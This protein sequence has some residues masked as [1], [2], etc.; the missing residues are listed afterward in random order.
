MVQNWM[1]NRQNAN[2][3]PVNACVHCKWTRLAFEKNGTSMTSLFNVIQKVHWQKHITYT[4]NALRSSFFHIF[5]LALLLPLVR[6]LKLLSWTVFFCLFWCIIS[7]TFFWHA[8]NLHLF[9]NYVMNSF[10]VVL[11]SIK[12]MISRIQLNHKIREEQKRKRTFLPLEFTFCV[13]CDSLVLEHNQFIKI[14]L[15]HFSLVMY[16]FVCLLL[17][18]R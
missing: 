4:P 12:A 3:I 17:T 16:A 2:V 5:H 13:F 15:R 1:E 14:V 18:L 8:L 11:N 9:C 10:F 6:S 7:L